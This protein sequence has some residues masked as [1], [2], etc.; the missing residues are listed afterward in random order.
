MKAII[1]GIPGAGK[2]TV[3][4]EVV[5]KCNIKVINYGDVMFEIA[6]KDGIAN[7]RDE[8]RKLP[9]EKQKELQKKAAEIISN[10]ENII[11]DTHCTIKTPYGYMAGLPYDILKV[12]KPDRII[13]IEAEPEEIIKRRNKDKE[14]R[15]RDV[16]SIEEM[17]LHQEMNRIAAMSYASFINAT[18]KIVRN[19]EGKIKEAAEEILKVLI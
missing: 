16:E 14:I 11:I 12:L 3:L 6:K 13:L 17:K 10:E 9:F 1:A 7:N 2:T 8:L 19:R 5:K 4:N 15:I 18:V